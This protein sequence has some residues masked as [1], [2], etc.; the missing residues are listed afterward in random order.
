MEI[1][2]L[3]RVDYLPT[4]EA[5]QAFTAARRIQSTQS[6]ESTEFINK[7]RLYGNEHGDNQLWICEHPAVYTQGLAGKVEHVLN[8]G[9]IPVVHTN[10]G[11]QVTFHG[12]GQVVAY[13]LLDLK[14]AGYFVK[15]YVY[16][17]EEAV[18]R[19]LAHFG[20]TDHR[21]MGAPGIYVRV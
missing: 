6:I 16:R 5:M 17:V 18:I 4:Y 3:G 9:D 21:V 10:R 19:T 15:E 14:R 11:G 7:N 1:S 12:P 13:P 8:A 2:Q 20:V